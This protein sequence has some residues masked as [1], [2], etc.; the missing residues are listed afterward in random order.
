M[1][2]TMSEKMSDNTLMSNIPLNGLI[3]M[4]NASYHTQCLEERLLYTS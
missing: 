3:L 2:T 1:N 4:D